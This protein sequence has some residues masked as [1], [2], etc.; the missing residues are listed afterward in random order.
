MTDTHIIVDWPACIERAN[1]KPELAKQLL[2]LFAK[3]LPGL[4]Q[5]ISVALQEENYIAVRDALHRLISGTSYCVTPT[6]LEIV[7]TFR[8]HVKATPVDLK[9]L[10]KDYHALVSAGEKIISYAK[11]HIQQ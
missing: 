4:L 2:E 7:Q 6:L 11:K 1:N 3:E 8:T 5:K 10:E 9:L